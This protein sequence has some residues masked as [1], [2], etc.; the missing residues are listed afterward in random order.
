VRANHWGN[1]GGNALAIDA[2]DNIF[3]GGTFVDTLDL[4]GG[5][6]NGPAH[7]TGNTGSFLAKLDPSGGYLHQLDAQGVNAFIGGLAT[8]SSGRVFVAAENGQYGMNLGG[9]SLNGTIVTGLL[10]A[11]LGHVW[12]QSFAGSSD[13]AT[14]VVADPSGAA[15][16]TGSYG[17]Y[18]SPPDFGLGA[19]PGT[20][21]AFVVRFDATGKALASFGSN[22]MG[23]ISYH[24]AVGMDIG[25]MAATDY[26]VV[27]SCVG[28]MTFPSGP[29]TCGDGGTTGNGFV[30]RLAP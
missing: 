18:S 22:A 9:G 7:N 3:L 12:S 13:Y 16:F 15:G 21:G 27:G 4:G 30:A 23:G 5:P 14:S 19:L 24:G 10:D 8:D 29:F 11:S 28:T 17:Q 25:W 20:Q 1:G 2:S 6:M 26:V